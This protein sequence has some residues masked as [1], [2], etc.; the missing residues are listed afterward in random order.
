MKTYQKTLIRPILKHMERAI[1]ALKFR[2]RE[3]E[4]DIVVMPSPI[5][6]VLKI[7]MENDRIAISALENFI[8]QNNKL[9]P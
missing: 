5:A 8:R 4:K 9:R 2:V 6:E 1:S 3:R 7:G